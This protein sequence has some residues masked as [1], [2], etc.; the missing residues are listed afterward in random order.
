MSNPINPEDLIKA[1]FK[2]DILSQGDVSRSM[3]DQ[4]RT[5]FTYAAHKGN[6]LNE[7]AI[8]LEGTELS[9]LRL[10]CI[11]RNKA[12]YKPY[13]LRLGELKPKLQQLSF[14][15]ER[16]MHSYIKKVLKLHVEKLAV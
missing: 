7:I 9:A 10:K 12:N 15:D 5:T 2:T 3:K 14:E 8:Q 6:T 4:I 1:Y 13:P 11:E 16:S